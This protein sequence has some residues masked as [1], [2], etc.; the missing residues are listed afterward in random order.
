MLLGNF[1]KTA[2]FAENA[3]SAPSDNS[4]IIKRGP[5]ANRTDSRDEEACIPLRRIHRVRVLG[6]ITIYSSLFLF[7]G[8][9]A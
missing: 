3:K 6:K 8:I 9:S 1:S 7:S 5:P 2:P 4:R